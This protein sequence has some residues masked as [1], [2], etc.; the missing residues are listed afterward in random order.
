MFQ[1]LFNFREDKLQDDEQ[2]EM[3]RETAER[4]NCEDS[5]QKIA[6]R[7]RRENLLREKALRRRWVH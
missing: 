3:L 7:V 4:C 5:V 2:I 1:K 6:R